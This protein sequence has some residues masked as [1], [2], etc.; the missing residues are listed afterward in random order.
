MSG[1]RLVEVTQGERQLRE[2]GE[3]SFIEE[4]REERH[5]ALN[6]ECVLSTLRADG[7]DHPLDK[8]NPVLLSEDAGFDHPVIFLDPDSPRLQFQQRAHERSPE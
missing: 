1:F 8:L 2:N 5:Q 7:N 3:T 6:D 4:S